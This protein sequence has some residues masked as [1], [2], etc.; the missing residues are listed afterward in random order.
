MVS[1]GAF[2]HVHLHLTMILELLMMSCLV[3]LITLFTFFFFFFF[4]SVLFS[5]PHLL[6]LMHWSM[7]LAFPML[8]GNYD[9][10]CH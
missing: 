10:K 6:E 2:H 1:F 8:Q 4:F 9:I 3:Q 7:Q 5:V